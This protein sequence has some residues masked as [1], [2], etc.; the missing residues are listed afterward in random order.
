MV[1]IIQRMVQTLYPGK[2]DELNKIDAKYNEI[3]AKYGFPQ[4]KKRYR[5]L[6]GSL[7]AN[8]IVIEFEWPSLSKMEK[9]MTKAY[10][11]PEYQK[12][13]EKLN[14]IL[15]DS[16]TEIYTPVISFEDLQGEI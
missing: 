9:A 1:V 8:K 12:L 11:D 6:M 3:E 7:G 10:L 15:M 5:C 4:N 13:S 14:S 16:V 2:L